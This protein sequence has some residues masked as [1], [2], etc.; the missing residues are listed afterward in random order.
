MPLEFSDS[1]INDPVA[2]RIKRPAR[3]IDDQWPVTSSAP[4]RAGIDHV[5]AWGPFPNETILP[6]LHPHEGRDGR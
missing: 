4:G 5:T 6:L 2:A 3:S 1:T